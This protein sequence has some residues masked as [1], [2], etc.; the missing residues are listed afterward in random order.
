MDPDS[1]S[2][3]DVIGRDVN[4]GSCHRVPDDRGRVRSRAVAFVPVRVGRVARRAGVV[5]VATGVIGDRCDRIASGP[6]LAAAGFGCQSD[7]GAVFKSRLG[8]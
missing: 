3:S 7:R 4:R 1:R 2:R 6:V 5:G 8:R